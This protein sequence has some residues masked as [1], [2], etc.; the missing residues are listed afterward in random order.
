MDARGRVPLA[1]AARAGVYIHELIEEFG[2]EQDFGLRCWLL[3]LIGSTKSPDAFDF[4][5]RQLQADDER[6]RS[7]AVSALK[8]LDTKEARTL[9]WQTGSI[10]LKRPDARGDG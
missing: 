5:A 2:K 4:L 10:T 8:K 7:R 3:E 6:L 1:V 9:L